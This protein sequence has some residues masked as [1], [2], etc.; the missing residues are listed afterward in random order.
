MPDLYVFVTERISIRYNYNLL[1][2]QECSQQTENDMSRVMR[3]PLVFPTRSDTN[4]AVQP[5]KM[6]RGLKFLIN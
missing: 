6:A 3:K 5:K 4:L 2:L 1:T